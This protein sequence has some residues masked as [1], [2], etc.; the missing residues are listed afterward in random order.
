VFELLKKVTTAPRP[1]L[2]ALRPELAPAVDDWVQLALAID[3]NQR[4]ERV[5]AMW[6]ALN[7]CLGG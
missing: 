5:R 6:N 3:P 4:F 2:R 1:S 7:A